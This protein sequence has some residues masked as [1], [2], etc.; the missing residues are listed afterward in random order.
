VIA[1]GGRGQKKRMWHRTVPAFACENWKN[2]QKAT[3]RRASGSSSSV[4]QAI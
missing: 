1:Y 3:H 4:V 2:E